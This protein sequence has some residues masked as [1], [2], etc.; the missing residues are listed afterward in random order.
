MSAIRLLIVDNHP[1]MIR[2]VGDVVDGQEEAE[3]AASV[4]G[5]PAVVLSIRKQ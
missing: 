4:G 1:I 5:K 2:D 3:T